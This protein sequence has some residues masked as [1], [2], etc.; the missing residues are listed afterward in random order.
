MSSSSPKIKA[1]MLLVVICISSLSIVTNR[2]IDVKSNS[3]KNIYSCTNLAI[4]KNDEI[5]FGNNEDSGED[6]PLFLH[7]EKSVIWFYPNS[8]EGYGMV[9]L[10][11]F[12]EGTHISFQGGVNEF[13]LSYD[14]TGIPDMLLNPHPEKS[15]NAETTYFWSSIL[16]NCR[17]VS[18]AIAFINNFNFGESMWYQIFLADAAGE[19]VVVSPNLNG[20]L[21]FTFKGT[22][23]SYL[24]QTNFNR[25][26][27]ESHIGKFPCPRYTTA[28]S[29]LSDM[30]DQSNLTY[31]DPMS[32]L[33]AVRQKSLI[34][35]AYSNVFDLQRNMLYLVYASQFE[36][37]VELNVT[38]ELSLSQHHYY[39]CDLFSTETI[40]NAISF[41]RCLKI[42]FYLSRVGIYLAIASVLFLIIFIPFKLVR[43]FKKKQVDNSI[44]T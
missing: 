20:E 19:A 42:K 11:W 43:R 36:E 8:I 38:Y 7:P 27:N 14:S 12:W 23:D 22:T 34:Y 33:E 16:R 21:N 24:A 28:I 41:V 10:G 39:I 5:Y 37:V 32:V 30:L 3:E 31:N 40:E 4:K 13:G 17:N 35:T 1:L 44:K 25:I 26:H 9:Q 29:L 6:H 2:I 15:Y 18:E